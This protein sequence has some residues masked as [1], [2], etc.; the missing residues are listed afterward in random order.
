MWA[1]AA[2]VAGGDDELSHG[3]RDHG[4]G[5]RLPF[6]TANHAI[7]RLWAQFD[8]ITLLHL[9]AHASC[10]NQI[11]IYFSILQR[12]DLTPAHFTAQAESPTVS[13]GSNRTNSRS[14]PFQWKFTT[15]P[16][17]SYGLRTPGSGTPSLDVAG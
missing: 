10:I 3:G 11:K 4:F 5:P 7:D 2:S 13:S 16:I 15:R 6:T 1:T 12:R 8:N 14:P 9:P 17:A